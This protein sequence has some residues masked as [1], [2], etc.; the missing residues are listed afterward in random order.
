MPFPFRLGQACNHIAALL[1]Y[2]EHHANDPELPTEIS[3]TSK[4]MAW[5]QPP[6]KTIPPACANNIKFVK[7]CH[8]DDLQPSTQLLQ[9]CSFD[10][11]YPQH[12]KIN[13]SSVNLLLAQVQK[14]MP[15][16]GLQQF[17]QSKPC[18]GHTIPT[19]EEIT[20]LWNYVIF[21]H[22]KITTIAQD[23]ILYL[24]L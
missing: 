9:R 17:W 22:Q 1:F 24:L 13:H 2:I 5:H 8:G 18:A 23:K 4:P 14:T 6:K 12:R 19:S 7:P 20:M 16:T 10:P 3:K 21:S 15:N 11:R